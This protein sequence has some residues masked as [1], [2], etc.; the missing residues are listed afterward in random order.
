MQF[1][2]PQFIEV[3]AKIIGPISARQF[4]E[5]LV[6]LGLC[7]GWYKLFSMYVF[8]PLIFLTCTIG[9][10]LAF[11][12]VN[13]QPMHY[14]LL[15]VIQ[16]MKRPRLKVWYRTRY[17]VQEIKVEEEK[18]VAVPK[19]PIEDSQL[20]SMSLMVDTGGAY[21]TDDVRQPDATVSAG[22]KKQPA[23]APAP[24]QKGQAQDS[25]ETI[26]LGQ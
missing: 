25:S 22:T 13:S 21:A 14:F 20:A 23:A 12:K 3:E 5:I 2:V 15:N 9:G 11:A 4:I 7:F 16:T 1:V 26:N 19:G 17:E 24:T 8:I 10:T 6:T 18:V